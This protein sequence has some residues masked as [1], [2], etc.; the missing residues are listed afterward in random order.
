M[1]GKITVIALLFCSF[2]FFSCNQSTSSKSSNVSITEFGYFAT[3][4]AYDFYSSSSTNR[5]SL[6]YTF[7]IVF[8]G[9]LT[10]TDISSAKVYINN[11][12]L[13]WTLSTDNFDESTQ[14]LHGSGFWY[15]ANMCELPV[16]MLTADIILTNG[17]EL[18]KEITMGI[19]GSKTNQAY[20]Y[21]YNADDETTPIYPSVT[22]KALR[23][24]II[25]SFN[26]TTDS[27]TISFKVVGDEVNNGFIWF[28]DSA[29]NFIGRAAYFRDP[30]TGSCFSG[31]NSGTGFNSQDGNTNIYIASSSCILI[32]NNLISATAFASISRAR[33]VVLDGSQYETATRH[34][35]FDYRAISEASK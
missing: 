15:T 6:S 11:S 35:S 26:R 23:R 12:N 9:G 18:T 20:Q 19:P 14:V 34:G 5:P 24:P 10:S 13:W 8:S 31:L 7:D 16:G 21:V 1:K 30:S 4:C 29:D 27:I 28:Y 32:N 17:T 2:L 33:V 25:T 22:Y 3:N